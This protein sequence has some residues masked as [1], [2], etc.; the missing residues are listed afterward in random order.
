MKKT[1]SFET[2]ISK[3]DAMAFSYLSK[4]HQSGPYFSNNIGDL[5]TL[6]STLRYIKNYL[7]NRSSNERI[8][9]LVLLYVARKEALTIDPNEII[10]QFSSGDR[11]VNFSY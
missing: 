7:R 8:R 1:S 10:N 5:R 4:I 3:L 9:D 11:A 6:L 2:F